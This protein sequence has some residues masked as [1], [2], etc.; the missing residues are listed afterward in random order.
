MSELEFIKLETPKH[1]AKTTPKEPKPLTPTQQKSRAAAW[2]NIQRYGKKH[3]H[4]HTIQPEFNGTFQD[5]E[6]GLHYYT[7][8]V[9]VITAKEPLNDVPTIQDADDRVKQRL[10]RIKHII[11]L[12]QKIIPGA[13]YGL[14]RE[15]IQ[16]IETAHK[17]KRLYIKLYGAVYTPAYLREMLRIIDPHKRGVHF[18]SAGNNVYFRGEHGLAL[19]ATCNVPD[20]MYKRY[21]KDNGYTD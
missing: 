16:R 17:D 8:S 21:I 5:E 1:S 7:S 20:E 2:R 18:A 15:D 11:N 19:L 12:H 9:L 10:E 14:N 3:G 13:W 4:L 6:T